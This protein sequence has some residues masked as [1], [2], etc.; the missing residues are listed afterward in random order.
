[1]NNA[2]LLT[3]GNLGDRE[4]NLQTAATYIE[5][6]TGNIVAKSEIYET[7]AWGITNQE[8]FLNQVLLIETSFKP[9]E[10]LKKLLAIEEKMGRKRLVKFGPRVIDIDILFYNNEIIKLE[11]LTIPHPEIQNRRFVLTPLND[12]APSY[13]H[14]VLNKNVHELLIDCK[15]LLEVRKYGS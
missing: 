13:V 6:I 5:Q 4:A 8:P 15:D 2:Y 7:A 1:M 10:V 12:I 9:T 11:S 14:P 3:G